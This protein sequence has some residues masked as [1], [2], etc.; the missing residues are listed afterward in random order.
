MADT[1]EGVLIADSHRLCRGGLMSIMSTELGLP[2]VAGVDDFAGAMAELDRDPQIGL[3]MVD[4][5]LPGMGGMDGLRRIRLHRPELRVVVMAWHQDRGEAFEA[6][7]AG[8]HGYVPKDLPSPEMVH[9]LQTVLNGQIYVPSI[10]SDVSLKGSPAAADGADHEGELTLRQREVL[11]HL[12]AGLSNKEIARAL[13]IAEGTVK[14]HI[15]A[16]F[17]TLH[18]HNRVGAAAALQKITAARRTGQPEIPGLINEAAPPLPRKS[19]FGSKFI[20]A[21]LPF[22]SEQAWMFDTSNWPNLG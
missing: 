8:A 15:T 6:L 18:V 3:L 5:R 19:D 4:F 11:T 20:V 22:C 7:S 9:A 2:A 14:V 1:R 17:R 10:I 13:N 16:A 21:C 12:A